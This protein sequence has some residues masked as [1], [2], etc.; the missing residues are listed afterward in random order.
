MRVGGEKPFMAVLTLTNERN[1]ARVCN[2]VATKSH[3]Q[4]E[5]ALKNVC[6]SLMLYGHPQPS[7]IYTDN[8]SDKK[9]LE[10]CFPSLRQGV[11]PVEKY[12]HLEELVIPSSTPILVKN[13]PNAIN[14]AMRTILDDIPQD[15]GSIVIGFD[16]EWNVDVSAQGRITRHGRTAIIQIAYENR[17]YILQVTIQLIHQVTKIEIELVQFQVTNMLARN[18]LPQQLKLLLSHPRVLK[19]GRLVNGDLAYLQKAC[20]S[21]EPFIGGIDLAKFAKDRRVASTAQSTLA[22]LCALTLKKRLN[23]NVP[24]CISQAWEDMTLTEEQLNYAARDVYASLAIY[25]YLSTVD[26]PCHLPAKPTALQ[27]VLLY[28]ADNTVVIAEG[29]ISAHFGDVQYDGINITPTKIVIDVLKVLVPGAIVTSH[30][31]RALNSFGPVPFTVV[32]L[33]SHLR[34]FNPATSFQENDVCGPGSN[35]PLSKM[36]SESSH[37]PAPL[38]EPEHGDDAAVPI[39]NLLSS[40]LPNSLEPSNSDIL[41]SVDAASAALGE[42]VLGPEQEIPDEPEFD[43]TLRSRVLK[44]PFH[45]FNM[46][47]IS[48]THSLR[49]HF[50][51]ELRDAIFVPDQ[52]DKSRIDSWGA[53]QDPPQTYNTLRNSSPQWIRERC[54]HIIPAPKKL[55]HLVSR[56]FR[57]YGPLIDPK[58]KKPLFTTDNWKTAKHVLDLIQ[59][60]YLSDPPGIPLYTV[61]GLDK[62]SGGLPLY[63]CARGTN[64]TEG[65]VH[66]HIRARLP[67]CGASLRHVNAAL[68]DFFLYH[69]LV[70][71]LLSELRHISP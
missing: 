43:S 13:N 64:A 26:V 66:K 28:N 67:K 6:N 61:F 37:P 46:F 15:Q 33:R 56:V 65:G 70:V 32:F 30:A 54:K 10:D 53:L 63:R 25:Q 7:I 12:G 60:G 48:A 45:V 52:A 36:L 21:P 51:R 19:V 41:L 42:K 31:K 27:P 16:S 71:S 17:I 38:E 3:S 59:N 9:F 58:T 68:H 4:Y 39:G 1:E 18:E 55:W 35:L 24:E 23:K 14:D 57:T 44:D 69:N 11:T 8:I 22:D 49:P 34:T 40:D 47:Y 5:L 29:Q 50:A 2:F 62:K 20:H